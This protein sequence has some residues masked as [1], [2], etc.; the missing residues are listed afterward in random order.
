MIRADFLLRRLFALALVLPFAV[1]GATPSRAEVHI[2]INR[3]KVEP[4]PIAIPD[5]AGNAANEIQLGRDM[6]QVISADGH[7]NEPPH[8]FDRVPAKFK[9]RAP[10]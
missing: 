10:R 2:D 9:D 4:L 6:T 1:L 5:F 8:V 3:A 7:I